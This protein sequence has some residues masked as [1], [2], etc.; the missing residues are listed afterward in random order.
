MP[1]GLLG[2]LS[3]TDVP[4]DMNAAQEHS[5]RIPKRRGCGVESLTQPW[6]LK[7]IPLACPGG[8]Q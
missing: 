2:P 5:A 8:S 7:V 6:L 4:L 3:I 1:Q